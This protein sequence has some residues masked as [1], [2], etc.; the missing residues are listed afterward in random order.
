LLPWDLYVSN[1]KGIT[2]KGWD[3]HRLNIYVELQPGIGLNQVAAVIKDA[4]LKAIRKLD[5]LREEVASDPEILL[6]PMNKW[7]LYSDF[8]EGVA[9]R[10][11]VQF[12]WLV[13]IIGAFVLLLACI[14]FMN[15]STARSAKRSKEVGIRKAIG[16]LRSQLVKQFFSESFLV[17]LFAF[18]IAILCVVISLNWFNGLASKEIGIPWTNA[19]FWAMNILFIVITSVLA[20]I[21]PALYLSSFRAVK[22]LKGTFRAGR[23]AAI[24]RKALVVLQFSVSI[25]L[26]ICTI[27]VYNQIVFAKD[28]PAGYTRDGLIMVPMVSTEF[29][30]KYDVLR[31]E[32]KKTGA[33]IE[34]AESESAV[35]DISSH[36]GGFTWRGK[37]V[38]TEEDFGTLSVSP[39]YGKT[40]GWQF[41]EGRDFSR[42]FASD[43]S[44]FVINEAAAKFM[45]L[46]H[47]VGEII[48]WENKWNRINKEFKV[49][50]VIKDMVMQS[51]YE[52][53]KP[54]IFR[55]GGNPNW[56][57]IRVD[58]NISTQSALLKI[59]SV[60]KHLLPSAP[61]EYKFV[62]DEYAKKFAT[63]VR[64]GRLATVFAVLAIFISCLGLFGLASFVAE[65]RTREI[66]IR[67]VLG[68]SVINLWQLLSKDFIVL[69]AIS[70]LIASPTAYYFLHN[71]LQKYEY[72]TSLAW[73]IFVLAIVVALLITLFTVSIQ[74]IKAAVANPVKNLRTE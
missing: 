71:W 41:L 65:Q 1:N 52:P 43:S 18:L 3:D 22:V 59:E 74:A 17:V 46:Q 19:W 45:G 70:G 36:N 31:N 54:T 26:I 60:F 7:H 10:G 67:K 11:P 55:L 69:V 63:E 34:M 49:L 48:R 25:A 38:R 20:G 51:P 8:K 58:S 4:E 14:N 15:L 37:D 68:A 24:P 64:I 9:N 13:A 12:V 62:D 42:E 61:F 32:L 47:P 6:H 16:S 2:Q 56:M 39:E 50:G 21:Y 23:L 57:F 28:R 27:I 30:G 73:W 29:Y 33:V 44:G 53:A 5:N 35:T 40:I 72:R 66:G